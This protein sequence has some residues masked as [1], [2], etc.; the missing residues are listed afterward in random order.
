MNQLIN[1][2]FVGISVSQTQSGSDE[3]SPIVS[4]STAPTITSKT[5]TSPVN[6]TVP[7]NNVN[8]SKQSPVQQRSN[9]LINNAM[10]TSRNQLNNSTIPNAWSI[11]TED[12][13]YAKSP[14][15]PHQPRGWLVD[16]INKYE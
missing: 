5:N 10:T 16:L 2:L 7:L 8:S 15:D 9:E 11:L 13:A 1:F 14:P 4:S 12:Q 3:L 6:T